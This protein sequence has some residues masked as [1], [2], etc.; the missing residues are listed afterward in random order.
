MEINGTHFRTIWLED[1]GWSVGIIDQTLLPHSFSTTQLKSLEEVCTA[2]ESMQVRGAPLIGVTAAY[3]LAL[4][5]K[6]DPS[7]TSMENAIQRLIET[8]PTAVNLQW[9]LEMVRT[10]IESLVGSERVAAAY[11]KASGLAD[12]DVSACSRI[13]RAALA[14]GP[15]APRTR[16]YFASIS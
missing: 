15:A 12:N 10:A 6:E 13:G 7:D 11:A 1:D 9:A 14:S 5:L 4:A 8:R 2:I 16:T 3:G